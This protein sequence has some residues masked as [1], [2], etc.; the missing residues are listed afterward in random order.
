MNNIIITSIICISVIIIVGILCYTNYK[1]DENAKSNRFFKT[2]T[3][4]AEQYDN[5]INEISNIKSLI[6]SIQSCIEFINTQI[7]NKENKDK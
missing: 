3:Y 5:I 7:S 2:V 6:N 1:N 4:T